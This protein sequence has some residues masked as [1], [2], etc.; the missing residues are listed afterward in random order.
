MDA[1]TAPVTVRVVAPESPPYEAVM[2]VEP[3]DTPVARPAAVIVAE[4]VEELQLAYA[5]MSCLV[6][7]EKMAVALNCR[8]VPFAMLGLVGETSTVVNVAAV[9]VSRVLPVFPP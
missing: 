1:R 3:L 6:V 8:D 7:S 9:T 5:V 4:A 2:E